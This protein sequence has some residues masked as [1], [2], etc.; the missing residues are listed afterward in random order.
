VS[1]GGQLGKT[2]RGDR[3][4]EKSAK[5]RTGAVPAERK[6]RPAWTEEDR[7]RATL[8]QLRSLAAKRYGA[9]GLSDKQRR[10]NFC[11]ENDHEDRA[12]LYAMIACGL[13][14][15]EAQKIAPWSV[16]T[17]EFDAMAN[18]VALKGSHYFTP[19]RLGFIVNLTDEERR[20]RRLNLL[21]PNDKDWGTVQ[22][23]RQQ[24]HST[25]TARSRR[26]DRA[27]KRALREATR[28]LDVRAEALW[29]AL[30]DQWQALPA[31]ASLIGK[32]DAWRGPD[33]R[34]VTGDNL[35]RVMTRAADDI[36]GKHAPDATRAIGSHAESEIRPGRRGQPV[37]WLRKRP[38]HRDTGTNTTP[39]RKNA[40]EHLTRTGTKKRCP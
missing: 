30:T 11:L 19:A 10:R 23:E 24:R 12:F 18:A 26:N 13:T 8:G 35:R 17:G 5:A 34:L 6:K 9:D 16:R 4:R 38:G 22:A 28:D 39:H 2:A 25:G 14:G 40:H 20:E 31:L 32:G 15:P 1:A 21:R 7:L 27:K 33:G 3:A 36:A 29:V 37:R